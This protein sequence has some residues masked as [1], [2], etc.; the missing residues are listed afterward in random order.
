MDPYEQNIINYIT[1]DNEEHFVDGGNE[2][3][4][5]E[6]SLYKLMNQSYSEDNNNKK[7]SS[8]SNEKSTGSREENKN[9]KLNKQQSILVSK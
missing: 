6:N 4:I 7:K 5:E 9:E 1:S 3:Y 8:N 2:N